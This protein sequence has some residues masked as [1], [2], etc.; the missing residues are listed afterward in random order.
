[1]DLAGRHVVVTGGAGGIGRA[2]IR[3]FAQESP[4]ALVVADLEIESAN[5][6]AQEVLSLIHI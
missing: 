5:A 4:R 6:I 2:L 1:M 3:R